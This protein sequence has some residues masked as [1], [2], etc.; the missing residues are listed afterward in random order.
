[1]SSV[2]VEDEKKEI[3]LQIVEI[4]KSCPLPIFLETVENSHL[5]DAVFDAMPKDVSDRL[6]EMKTRR[7]ENIKLCAKACRR[8]KTQETACLVCGK[9]EANMLSKTE[10]C[11][12]TVL[13]IE[14]VVKHRLTT[15][16]VCR[17]LASW[18]P[19]RKQ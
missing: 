16:P 10:E 3:I 5:K 14:C 6:L 18:L 9:N 15:C 8:A 11:Y 7:Q 1:M 4:L 13:C 12:H 17:K 19:L 2:E